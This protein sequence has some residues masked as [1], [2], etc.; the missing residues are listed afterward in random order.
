MPRT[1][2]EVWG[3]F[4][5]LYS[6]FRCAGGHLLTVSVYIINKIKICTWYT[7][8]II[9]LWILWKMRYKK[10][11]PL[12]NRGLRMRLPI[13]HCEFLCEEH[14]EICVVFHNLECGFLFHTKNPQSIQIFFHTQNLVHSAVHRKRFSLKINNF[15][16][17]SLR[18][19]K[20]SYPHRANLLLIGIIQVR[21]FSLFRW[22][23]V[24]IVPC[25]QV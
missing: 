9:T 13:W 16:F 10:K 3:Y 4:Y 25:R 18:D 21:G 8:I 15:L 1:L 2:I 14:V 5:R 24:Y 22:G 23:Y 19:C 20:L 6:C 17:L 11:N 12:K 7:I